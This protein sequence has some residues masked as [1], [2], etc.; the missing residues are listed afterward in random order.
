MTALSPDLLSNETSLPAISIIV[1]TWN[2]ADVTLDCLASL[3]QLNYPVDRLQIIVC[4]N[5][6][7][8]NT[9]AIIREQYPHVVMI[10]NGD[11][12][13]FAEGNNVGIRFALQNNADYV[14]L[15]NN[16]TIVD[17]EMLNELLR[18]VGTDPAIGIVGPKMLYY[19]HPDVIWCAGNKIDWHDGD[20]SR[21]QADEHDDSV[22]NAPREVDF[23]TGCAICLR[24]QVI[25][26]I[27]MLD[28]RFFIYYEE[29]DWCVRAH[30]AGWRILYVPRARL[31]H[32]VSMAMGTTSPATEYYMNRNV[33][34]FL[35]KNRT[36]LQKYTSIYRAM[37]RSLLAI[38]AYTVK[39]HRGQRLPRRNAR[40][41]ALRDA[42]LRRWG[43]MGPDVAHAYYP[44]KP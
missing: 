39:S 32:K 1:L 25:D 31:L 29:T 34:L 44:K 22:D 9:P 15:L 11:N 14:V 7:Q 28:P 42:V 20:T 16:D 18:V 27:G 17:R 37:L 19:D 26:Q 43:K 4:D 36:G 13:G 35:A 5:G 24:R 2:Q 6:S 3:A 12:L 10:E 40:W 41:F 21:L 38:G 8:D 33:L 23:I 30:S